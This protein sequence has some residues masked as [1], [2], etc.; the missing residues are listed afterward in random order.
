MNNGG[1]V[2]GTEYPSQ[3]SIESPNIVQAATMCFFVL[4]GIN[5]VLDVCAHIW[6]SHTSD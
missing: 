5:S 3:Q 6:L 2:Q 4:D 1:R